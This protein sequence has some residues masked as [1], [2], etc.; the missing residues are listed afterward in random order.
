MSAA[1]MIA[2]SIRQPWAHL[3]LTRGK[4]VE[5]RSWPLPANYLGQTILIHAGIAK[6]TEHP[7][8]YHFLDLPRGGIVGM[9]QITGCVRD[10]LSDW[11]E[12][13]MYHWLLTNARTLPFHPCK[14]R[15]GFFEV[16]YPHVQAQLR[17]QA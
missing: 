15:L 11:A 1:R 12:P 10:S 9:V 3:I 2:I 5:N 16:D 14:G 7:S 17:V 6:P 13:T 4:D 8:A